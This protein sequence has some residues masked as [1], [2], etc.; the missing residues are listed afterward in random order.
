MSE[1]TTEQAVTC[2]M[3][4]TDPFDFAQCETHD[5]TFALGDRC[6]FYGR[7]PE[8]VYYDEAQEQRGRAVI[9][10]MERAEAL[11]LLGLYRDEDECRW[12]HH[13]QCQTH[14][15]HSELPPGICA[16]TLI[17]DLLTRHGQDAKP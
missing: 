15:P 13:R 11:D 5:T 17:R 3:T 7:E 12:D 9:A 14:G 8:D 4:Q 6:K 10:E 2:V 1:P 16:M